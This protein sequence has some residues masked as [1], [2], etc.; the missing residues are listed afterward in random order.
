MANPDIIAFATWSAI[1]AIFLTV[2]GLVYR[3]FK[4]KKDA[5]SSH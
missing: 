4:M 3:R 5:P 1:T 2:I